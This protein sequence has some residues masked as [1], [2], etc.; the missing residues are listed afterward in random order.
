MGLA[1]HSLCRPEAGR[2]SWSFFAAIAGRRVNSTPGDGFYDE[3]VIRSFRTSHH[4]RS[5]FVS[6]STDRSGGIM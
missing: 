5:N 3:K 4:A 6:T 2:A 1:P